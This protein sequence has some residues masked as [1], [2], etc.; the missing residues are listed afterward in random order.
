VD[1]LLLT[2]EHA[3]EALAVGRTKLY[4]LLRTG[5]LESV[6]IGAARRIPAAALTAYVEHLRQQE[7]ADVDGYRDRVVS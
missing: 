7:A 5:A 6:R 2:P 4:E 1:Q 3:A